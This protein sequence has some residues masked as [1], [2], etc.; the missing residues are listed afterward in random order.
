M[1]GLLA[2]AP[3]LKKKKTDHISRLITSSVVD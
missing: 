2:R 1:F 3:N